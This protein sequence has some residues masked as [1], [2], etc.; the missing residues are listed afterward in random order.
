MQAVNTRITFGSLLRVA[1]S[2]G[3][4]LSVVKNDINFYHPVFLALFIVT[5]A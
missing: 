1:P 5:L 4:Q 2:T 3:H